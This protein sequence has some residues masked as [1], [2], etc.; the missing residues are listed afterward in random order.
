[1]RL[2]QWEKNARRYDRGSSEMPMSQARR[3]AVKERR[4][5]LQVRHHAASRA[6]SR[7]LLVTVFIAPS[8]PLLADSPSAH[9][10]F[11]N[12]VIPVL[13]RAGCNQGTCHGA[14]AGKN[15]FKLTLRGYAPELDYLVLTRQS[16]GRRINR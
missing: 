2:V 5:R 1:I 10:S 9:R 7:L 15:G 12:D 11:V 16:N 4:R 13:T 6:V 14:A 8:F 3:N